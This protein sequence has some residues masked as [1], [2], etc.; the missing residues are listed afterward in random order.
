MRRIGQ[1][2]AN[3]TAAVGIDWAFGPTLAVPQDDRWGRTYEGYSP[4]NLVRQGNADL[5]LEIE[6]RVDEKPTAP[7]RLAMI[8]G[9]GCSGAL[10]LTSVLDRATRGQWHTLKVRLA[11]FKKAGAN[12]SELIE[13]FALTTR[14]RLSITLMTV[15]L[16]TDS[17]GVATLPAAQH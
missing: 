4:F 16:G 12:L 9:T 3:E 1:A 7:V 8:C 17:V 15:R 13:P 10:D 6:Y 14:G 11:D 5:L 2:T